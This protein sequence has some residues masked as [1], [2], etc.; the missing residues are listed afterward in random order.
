MLL[1]L[2]IFVC[3]LGARLLC[4]E[5]SGFDLDDRLFMLLRQSSDFCLV[6]S[7]QLGAHFLVALGRLCDDFLQLDDQLL[8]FLQ[9]NPVLFLLAEE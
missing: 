7:F 5:K 4:L 9:L 6:V 2:S 8:T 3:N 1:I